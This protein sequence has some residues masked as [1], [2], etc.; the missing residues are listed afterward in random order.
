MLFWRKYEMK[1]ISDKNTYRVRKSNA[2]KII[3]QGECDS[4]YKLKNVAEKRFREGLEN[5][6]S[7]TEWTGMDYP[8]N[9]F[10]ECVEVIGEDLSIGKV[11]KG[12]NNLDDHQLMMI[13][14]RYKDSLTYRD[15]VH[16]GVFK[17]FVEA[18]EHYRRI[19]SKIY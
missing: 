18:K 7:A 5:V 12:L 16:Q 19:I 6:L 10:S 17:N 1:R 3:E 9:L 15:Q 13:K 11:L 4:V 14:M 2:K 8:F